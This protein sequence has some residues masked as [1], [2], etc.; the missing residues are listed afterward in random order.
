MLI[1]TSLHDTDLL[2][3]TPTLFGK[4]MD[5]YSTIAGPVVV[6]IPY[7]LYRILLR[8]GQ[9]PLYEELTN[10][11]KSAEALKNNEMMWESVEG[12]L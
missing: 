1:L 7:V 6:S 9:A 8:L 11:I 2:E 12:V 3:R 4:V 10:S 5:V